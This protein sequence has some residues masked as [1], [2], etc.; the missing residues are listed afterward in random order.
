M[1]K[2]EH[3]Q[4]SNEDH[5]LIIQAINDLREDMTAQFK[6]IDG[7]LA[8]LDNMRGFWK[9][10]AFIL[11]VVTVFGGAIITVKGAWGIVRSHI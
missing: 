4:C 7:R 3:T 9:T 10:L 11:G 8:P 6:T 2:H 1:P 5:D